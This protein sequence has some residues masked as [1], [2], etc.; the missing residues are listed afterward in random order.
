MI[1]HISGSV[2]EKKEDSIIIDVNGLGYQV[3]VASHIINRL[4]TESDDAIKLYTYHHIREDQQVLFGFSTLEE[5]GLFTLLTTVSGVGPKAAL[6]IMSNCFPAQL[7]KAIAGED[8]SVLTSIP[9]IGKKM[10][11]RLIIELKDKLGSLS[12]SFSVPAFSVKPKKN[13]GDFGDDLKTALKTLGYSNDESRK[14]FS[15][16]LSEL[17][18]ELSLEQGLKI[19]LKHL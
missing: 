12:T 19:L 18:E 10:A 2:I 5:R 16:A 17:S 1:Y 8:L 6:K 11:E 13:L 7:I 4:T 14:A 3:F 9:G 15:N